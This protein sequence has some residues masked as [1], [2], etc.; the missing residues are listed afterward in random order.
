VRARRDTMTPLGAL[1][2]G[3]LAG[4]AGTAAMDTVWY[5]RYR[6]GGGQQNFLAW[7]TAAG[8]DKWDDAPAP[9]QVGRRLV[10]G[11]LRQELPDGWARTM[12]NVMHWVT[13]MGWGAQY[14]VVAGSVRRR[15]LVLA[16]TFGPTVWLSSYVILPLAK[17][18]QPIWEYDAK[19]LAKD[20]SAHMVYGTVSAT[21]FAVLAERS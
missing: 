6:R 1:V 14:G 15:R 7:E 13:G 8:V 20:L 4:V 9:G 18:Y 21:A 11:F 16:A 2:G 12:T 3:A 5:A 17:L 10:E 19:T